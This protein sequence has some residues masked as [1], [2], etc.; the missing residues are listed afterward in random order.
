M[1]QLKIYNVMAWEKIIEKDKITSVSDEFYDNVLKK[2]RIHIQSRKTERFFH[3]KHIWMSVAA[4]ILLGLI[5]LNLQNHIQ[6]S[7]IENISKG[8]LD[9]PL[10]PGRYGHRKSGLYHFLN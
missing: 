4:R 6:E 1:V 3:K 5:M 7:G 2:L 10:L 8:S 9:Q